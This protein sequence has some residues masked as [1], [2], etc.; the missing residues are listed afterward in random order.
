MTEPA[1]KPRAT[2]A[3]PP[4]A[5]PRTDTIWRSLTIFCRYRVIVSVI[6]ALFYWGMQRQSFFEPSHLPLAI[7]ALGFLFIAAVGL[8]A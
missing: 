5:H 3:D 4:A 7:G 6:L 2:P 1:A 8:L